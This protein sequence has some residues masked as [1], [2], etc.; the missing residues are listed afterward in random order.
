MFTKL[1]YFTLLFH[2]I[3]NLER[4]FFINEIYAAIGLLILAA[5][6]IYGRN[7]L[8]LSN[9]S[10]FGVY[11]AY[12]TVQFLIS[13]PILLEHGPIV[14]RTYPVYYSFFS[15]Y[16]G[17][18]LYHNREKIEFFKNKVISLAPVFLGGVL[19]NSIA[20]LFTSGG[21][22][23]I[24]ALFFFIILIFFKNGIMNQGSSTIVINL[25]IFLCAL[26]FRAQTIR[27]A[28]FLLSFRFI[29]FFFLLLAA[30]L[31]SIYPLF[32]PLAELGLIPLNFIDPNNLWRI[33]FWS[34]SLHELWVDGDILFGKGLGV[35][36]FNYDSPDSKFL[37]DANPDDPNLSFTIGLHNSFIYLIVRYGLIGF[38][39][40]SIPFFD[41]LKRS[42]L[43]S[44]LE[45]LD[46]I[47]ALGL[48]FLCVNA[49]FNVIMESPLYASIFWIFSGYCLSF[50]SHTK[51]NE[52]PQV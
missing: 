22:I 35:P 16:L 11:L 29:F 44:K 38:I 47:F 41:L 39:L 2:L 12:T 51:I 15:V 27:A 9:F 5:S 7:V 36:L 19:S 21:R 13:L 14:I 8:F 23:T 33:L 26:F 30:V 31:I 28:S 42:V 52:K 6:T 1:I 46:G 37:I 18:Y 20:I 43:A 50:S 10:G 45:G 49:F 34:K 40:F 32:S 3:Q 25:A 4:V 17:S 48:V 24:Q